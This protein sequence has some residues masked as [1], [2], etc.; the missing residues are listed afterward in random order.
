MGQQKEG[1]DGSPTGATKE[2]KGRNIGVG[3]AQRRASVDE[4]QIKRE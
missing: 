3:N 4:C 1:E 2:I